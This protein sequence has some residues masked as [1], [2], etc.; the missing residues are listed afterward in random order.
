MA[1]GGWVDWVDWVGGEGMVLG[2][3]AEDT[4]AWTSIR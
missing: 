1:Q 4:S 2:M 3:E